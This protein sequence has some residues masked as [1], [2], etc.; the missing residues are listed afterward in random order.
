[1]ATFLL[2]GAY[3]LAGSAVAGAI[4]FYCHKR[5]ASKK[6]ASNDEVT[7]APSHGTFTMPSPEPLKDFVLEKALPLA[8]RPF[9][10]GHNPIT[11]GTRMLAWD[12]WLFIDSLYPYY[13]EQK[14]KGLTTH[15]SDHVA[16]LDPER[17]SP[18]IYELLEEVVR[19]HTTR[20]PSIFQ[21]KGDE[22]HNRVTGE[23]Y[24]ICGSKFLCGF[25]LRKC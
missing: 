23:C 6:G 2:N 18:A 16:Q 17:T 25:A 4:L 21:Q 7:S 5:V 20:Y 14:D 19:F 8:Y 12:D 1:M 22:V 15:L 3:T 10:H 9:K 13:H 11:M 24:H